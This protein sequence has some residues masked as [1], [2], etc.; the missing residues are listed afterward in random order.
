M[1]EKTVTVNSD[2]YSLAQRAI[3]NLKTA[4]LKTVSVGPKRRNE[5]CRNRTKSWDL[6]GACK[7]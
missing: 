7:A 6:Y 2:A 1:G 4:V 5:E 3:A